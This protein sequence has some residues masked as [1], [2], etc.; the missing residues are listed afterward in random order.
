TAFWFTS[1]ILEEF[2]SEFLIT[3]DVANS[4]SYAWS[5]TLE[6]TMTSLKDH[7]CLLH[8]VEVITAAMHFGVKKHYSS[9][10]RLQVDLVSHK[11]MSRT[12]TLLCRSNV[13]SFTNRSRKTEGSAG[14]RTLTERETEARTQRRQMAKTED[15]ESRRARA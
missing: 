9:H 1:N 8:Y 4:R 15:L 13:P 6:R 2:F 3:K 5:I 12:N 14:D 7:R 11:G 10:K